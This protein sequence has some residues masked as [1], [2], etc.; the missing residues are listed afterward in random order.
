MS[1][2]WCSEELSRYDRQWGY[3]LVTESEGG[4][5]LPALVVIP[6][7]RIEQFHT[8][9]SLDEFGVEIEESK[10]FQVDRT[11]Q[12]DVPLAVFEHSLEGQL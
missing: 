1:R 5:L 9:V 11:G 2:Y 7:T 12:R 10:S 8:V 4:H 3:I 6:H